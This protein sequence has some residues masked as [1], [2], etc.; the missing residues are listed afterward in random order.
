MLNNK[1]NSIS[2]KKKAQIFEAAQKLN[3]FPNRQAAALVTKK[4]N[5][6][7]LII[8]DNCNNFFAS[9]SK[10]IEIC[11]R[12]KGYNLI[13]GNSSNDSSNDYNYALM[14]LERCV[15][16]I[17][18]V[19]SAS[20]DR[21]STERL[22]GLLKVSPVPLVVL[23]RDIEGLDAPAFTVD[24]DYGGYIATRH[25]IEQG[26]RRIGCYTGPLDVS[27]AI[28]R[29]AGYRRALTEA[30]LYFHPELI[31]EGNYQL[32]SEAQAFEHFE[33]LGVSAVFAQNDIMAYGLY[34]QIQ[35]AGKK[36]PDDYALVGFDDLYISTII[37]PSLSSVSQPVSQLGKAAVLQLLS[38]INEECVGE[39]PKRS[40]L[41]EL[42]I[43]DSSRH[44]RIADAQPK[45]PI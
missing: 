4:S 1:P 9:L 33:S 16:G 30:G 32:G 42:I 28:E 34:H 2:E 6:I 17:I 20:S 12:E 22:K 41:P 8:P 25:L 23:D 43:R 24:N 35:R 44:T 36:I 3:Y 14:F 10:E 5:S 26:H 21:Q 31:F 11:A 7:G 19:R 18:L 27:S 40:F 38:M 29:L 39:S 13:Y 45:K 37:S 15:D